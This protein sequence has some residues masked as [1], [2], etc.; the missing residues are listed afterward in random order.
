[1][2]Q[3]WMEGVS[4]LAHSGRYKRAS[5]TKA[6]AKVRF[7]DLSIWLRSFGRK[8]EEKDKQR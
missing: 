8:N 3:R 1:M 5:H 4:V 2:F 6:K 7:A